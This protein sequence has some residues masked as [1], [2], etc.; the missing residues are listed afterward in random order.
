M[1]SWVYVSICWI[2]TY[3]SISHFLV[4]TLKYWTCSRACVFLASYQTLSVPS[5][6][7]RS[8]FGFLRTPFLH[9]LCCFLKCSFIFVIK[10]IKK[11]QRLLLSCCFL[12]ISILIPAALWPGLRSGPYFLTV[13]VCVG[14]S[15]H[16]PAGPAS[17]RVELLKPFCGNRYAHFRGL[18]QEN[19]L[20]SCLNPCSA[21]LYFTEEFP[22]GDHALIPNLD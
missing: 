8:T 6:Y 14:K 21:N 7:V 9:L 1:F 15:H 5:A 13:C 16:H 17:D 22:V 10:N 12:Y 2:R 19:T 4:I 18:A 20:V 3:N 11:I